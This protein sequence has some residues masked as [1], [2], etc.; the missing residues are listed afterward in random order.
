MALAV[1]AAAERRVHGEEALA[2]AVPGPLLVP[3]AAGF[4]SRA[5][6]VDERPPLAAAVALADRE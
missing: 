2:A 4:E 3:E 6:V 5:V 1:L